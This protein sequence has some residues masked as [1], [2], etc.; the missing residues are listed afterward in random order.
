MVLI[1][2]N[3]GFNLVEY[4]SCLLGPAEYDIRK[5]DR[6]PKYSLAKRLPI[7]LSKLYY[8]MLNYHVVILY[9]LLS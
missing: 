9:T 7:H 6:G 8:I 4:S 3:Y 5:D 1:V 2:V